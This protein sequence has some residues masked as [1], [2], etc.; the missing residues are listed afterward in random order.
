M[1]RT[2][3][4]AATVPRPLPARSFGSAPSMQLSFGE[5][6]LVLY[7]VAFYF[8]PMIFDF[9]FDIGIKYHLSGDLPFVVPFVF[10]ILY[11][12][13]VLAIRRIF[14]PNIKI[15]VPFR[16][17]MGS[18]LLSYGIFFIFAVAAFLFSTRFS[19]SFRHTQNYADAG[20]LP[21][22]V[23]SVKIICHIFIFASLSSKRLI[24]LTAVHYLCYF[25]GLFFA[26]VSSYDFLWAAVGM[27]SW[28]RVANID[29][30]RIFRNWFS[31]FGLISGVIIVPIVVFGGMLN[32]MGLE[33]ALNYFSDGLIM[34]LFELFT[35]R[36][37]Y[38]SYSL[39]MHLNDIGRS[40]ALSFEAMNILGHQ[41]LRRLFILIGSPIPSE[42]AQ[43][44]SRLNFLVIS[45]NNHLSDAGASPGLLG[46][47]FYLPGGLFALPIHIICISNMI[48][49][50]DN[51]LGKGKYALPSYFGS[52]ALCQALTD[53][54]MDNFNP[55]SI[56]FIAL[57]TMFVMS[58]YARTVTDPADP[59]RRRRS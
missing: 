55:F 40:F 26:F 42:T 5:K 31:K 34:G 38:H 43:T 20:L 14:M 6:T 9:F 57:A 45:G 19:S 51:I 54:F 47:I 21:V 16:K 13:L 24:R 3:D 8:F 7:F 56:G 1:S 33:G 36:I 22:V 49:M 39:A 52:L 50:F 23:F 4:K 12:L 41:S 58:S 25:A 17:I 59:N 37:F 46:S 27:Y 28:I 35:N 2:V 32:K 48:G 44:V 11:L 10:S 53:A 18:K 15:R 29:L 30:L